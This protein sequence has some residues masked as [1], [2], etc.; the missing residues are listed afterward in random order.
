M[1]KDT[2]NPNMRQPNGGCTFVRTHRHKPK[3]V[4]AVHQHRSCLDGYEYNVTVTSQSTKALQ[5]LGQAYLD[6]IGTQYEPYLV[7]HIEYG[8]N[9][10]ATHP[11]PDNF[12]TTFS[13][14]E[15]AAHHQCWKQEVT[16]YEITSD[17]I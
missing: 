15:F 13:L 9:K 2:Y 6:T 3:I 7:A 17:N 11:K 14:A 4:Y 5:M 8:F 12:Q 1:S 16:D 10:F